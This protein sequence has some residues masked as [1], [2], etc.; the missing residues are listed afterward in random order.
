MSMYE[1]VRDRC[2]EKVR[3]G[4]GR[5]CRLDKHHAGYHASRVFQCDGCGQ[6]FRGRPWGTE[7][8]GDGNRLNF[9]YPCAEGLR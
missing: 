7:I 8:E 1:H 4:K 5:T 3:G 9:C 6:T 2:G